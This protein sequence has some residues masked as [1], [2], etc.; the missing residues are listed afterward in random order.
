MQ[1]CYSTP[2]T[3]YSGNFLKTRTPQTNNVT[4]GSVIFSNISRHTREPKSGS[5]YNAYGTIIAAVCNTTFTTKTRKSS[6]KI[7]FILFAS[8][9]VRYQ[10]THNHYKQFVFNY[11]LS[12]HHVALGPTRITNDYH[13]KLRVNFILGGKIQLEAYELLSC[14]CIYTDRLDDR[15]NKP[16]LVLRSEKEFKSLTNM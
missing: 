8:R 15:L 9:A 1:T 4:S 6:D 7:V 16:K 5:T 13:S 14:K 12:F 10:T 11:I 3:T 2:I